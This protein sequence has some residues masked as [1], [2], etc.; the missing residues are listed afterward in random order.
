MAVTFRIAKHSIEKGVSLVEI[1]KDGKVIGSVYPNGE[2]GIKVVSAHIEDTKVEEGF[3]GEAR[4]DDRKV[5]PPI[6]AVLIYFH[7]SPYVIR[8][9]RIIRTT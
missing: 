9:D 5:W 4:E 2:S 1:L 6:P 3:A 8:G 7:P